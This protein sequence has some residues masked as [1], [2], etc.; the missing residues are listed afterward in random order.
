MLAARVETYMDRALQAGTMPKDDIV[1]VAVISQ[2]LDRDPMDVQSAYM[3][4]SVGFQQAFRRL[5]DGSAIEKRLKE[6]N[7]PIE[8]GGA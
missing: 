3:D 5:T 4:A 8:G 6:A 7:P 1:L 2:L